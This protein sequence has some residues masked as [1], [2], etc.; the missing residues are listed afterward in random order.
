MKTSS[1]IYKRLEDIGRIRLS[2]N[3]F[4]RDFLYSEIAITYGIVN[5]PGNLE[6]AIEA[7]TNLCEKILEPI[8]NSWDRIHIRSAFRSEEV[9]QIGNIKKHN[10]A[11]NSSNYGAHIW[12]IRDA[13]G[14]L[15]ATACI[16]IPKYLEHFNKS[17]DWVSLAWWLHHEI[18]E[19]SDMCFFKSSCAFNIRWSENTKKQQKIKSFLVNHETGDKSYLVSKGIEHSHYQNMD[20]EVKYLACTEI[21]C[22]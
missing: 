13:E 16:V 8:Q 9:N 14:Y 3:F 22:S 4:M 6:L 19:Y 20:K 12:D 18:P 21:L 2:D 10:C 7:G 1:S 5:V 17:E 11:S 15:G